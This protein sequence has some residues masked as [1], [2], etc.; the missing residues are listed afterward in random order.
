MGQF[1]IDACFNARANR[2]RPDKKGT[3]ERLLITTSILFLLRNTLTYAVE[4]RYSGLI[5]TK[6]ISIIEKSGL[7]VVINSTTIVQQPLAKA[8]AAIIPGCKRQFCTS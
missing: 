2:Y 5:K 3:K 6:A 8:R 7:L 4:T 1:L